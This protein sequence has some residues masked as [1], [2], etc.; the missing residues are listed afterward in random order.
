M[1]MIMTILRR[2]SWSVQSAP[3][4]RIERARLQEEYE[5]LYGRRSWTQL[6]LNKFF[7]LVGMLKQV[8][9][10]PIEKVPFVVLSSSVFDKPP[11]NQEAIDLLEDEF[12]RLLQPLP[13]HRVLLSKLH[14]SSDLHLTEA[15]QNMY[16][17]PL[18]IERTGMFRMKRLLR[19]MNSLVKPK[20][21]KKKEQPKYL[22][23]ALQ[24]RRCPNVPP[25]RHLAAAAPPRPPPT[26]PSRSSG[27]IARQGSSDLPMTVSAPPPSRNGLY[28]RWGHVPP[29]TSDLLPPGLPPGFPSSTLFYDV[30]RQ[31]RDFPPAFLPADPAHYADP[32]DVV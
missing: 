28:G 21:S 13:G 15:Y 10:I 12:V 29:P 31:V 1:M 22:T 17:K 7:Q 4:Q 27:I 8:K 32:A 19:A 5:R 9:V 6:R 26:L 16:G 25:P 23:L 14:S 18:R 11:I 30:P 3:Q 2:R 20:G 24:C